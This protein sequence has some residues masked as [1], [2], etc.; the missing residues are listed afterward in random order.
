MVYPCFHRY[1]NALIGIRPQRWDRIPVFSLVYEWFH[2][3][4]K[5]SIGIRPQ[6]WGRMLIFLIGSSMLFVASPI[7]QLVS[8]PSAGVGYPRVAIS[9][10]YDFTCFGPWLSSVWHPGPLGTD[11]GLLAMRFV[12][13]GY[14][15]CGWLPFWALAHLGPIWACLLRA[16][17]ALATR[18]CGWPI[19]R[20]LAGPLG[21]SC[22]L[23]FPNRFPNVS[24]VFP[25]LF[26]KC[27]PLFP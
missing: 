6:R 17:Y 26:L 10:L 13:A 3:F 12:R 19:W 11:L 24:L 5:V 25:Q 21:P 14:A 22:S 8:A 9:K 15:L 20:N 23:L 1:I 18:I 27:F 2:W 16:S 7:F 4:I